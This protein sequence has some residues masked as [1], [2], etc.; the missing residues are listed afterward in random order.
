MA[1]ANVKLRAK[2]LILATGLVAFS[3]IAIGVRVDTAG[4]GV[5]VIS[6]DGSIVIPTS[7][8]RPGTARF[9]EYRDSAGGRIRFILA[10]DEDGHIHAALDACERCYIHHQGYAAAHGYLTCRYCG[11]RYKLA[12][13]TKGVA[14]CV[15]MK[16]RIQIVGQTV[17][18][19]TA[20]LERHRRFFQ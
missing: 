18:I 5:T 20:E 14:S 2:L 6:G 4:S 7:E 12:A 16:L 11:N 9:Y 3:I 1:A 8:I 17:R 10:S 13:M 15:P 19:K